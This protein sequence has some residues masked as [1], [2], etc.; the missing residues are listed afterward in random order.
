MEV[1]NL[2]YNQQ[3]QLIT[4]IEHGICVAFESLEKHLQRSHGTKGDSLRA[5][6]T[7]ASQLHVR[8]PRQINAPV[9]SSP[10]PYLPIDTEY[11]CGYTACN[12]GKG[13]LSKHKRAVEKHLAKEHNIGHAK[14]KTQPTF[15]DVQMVCVQSFCTGDKYRP[16]VVHADGV[17]ND[18]SATSSVEDSS[19]HAATSPHA[20][21]EAFDPMRVELGQEYERSQRDWESTFERLQSTTN[22]YADQTPPWLRTTGIS[23]WMTKLHTD[24]KRLRE[25]LHANTNDEFFSMAT[26]RALQLTACNRC[27]RASSTLLGRSS[28]AS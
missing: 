26:S 27:Y 6:L 4:C 12:G 22:P 17:R 24:K 1:C 11:R 10:I 21:D 3:L 18:I 2:N 9:N 28:G 14:G 13:A 7:E 25:L 15:N 8:D 20:V 5:A 23:R 19:S 16:F